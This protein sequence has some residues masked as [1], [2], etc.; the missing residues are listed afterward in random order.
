M[1]RNESEITA[2]IRAVLSAA[3]VWVWKHWQGPISESE[4]LRGSEPSIA[5]R[6]WTPAREANQHNNKE[7]NMARRK[8]STFGDEGEP[9]ACRCPRCG[10][11]HTQILY[12]TGRGTPRIYC[13]D[14]AGHAE[15]IEYNHTADFH[16][17]PVQI[18]LLPLIPTMPAAIIAIKRNNRLA[19][20]EKI[21][22]NCSP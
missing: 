11:T 16:D 18:S 3:G 4:P 10:K 9:T 1:T 13:P 14:C 7:V 2:A 19:K 17:D 6:P 15:D 5:R 12:W 20:K 22:Y 8:L 21:R